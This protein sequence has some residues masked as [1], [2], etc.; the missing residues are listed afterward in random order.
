MEKSLLTCK[1]EY[2]RLKLV[3]QAYF[4][5]G[6]HKQ[7]FVYKSCCKQCG[8]VTEKDKEN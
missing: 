7:W 8:K 6:K 4:Y 5:N 3:A 1:H 2:N